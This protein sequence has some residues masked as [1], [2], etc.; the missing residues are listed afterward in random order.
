MELIV[1]I[2]GLVLLAVASLRYGYDSRDDAQV[3]GA[4]ARGIRPAS[5]TA[6]ALRAIATQRHAYVD[7]IVAASSAEPQPIPAAHPVV[8]VPR[9]AA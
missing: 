1:I 9:R 7:G 2:G 8:R 4:L 6:E 3:G 5:S